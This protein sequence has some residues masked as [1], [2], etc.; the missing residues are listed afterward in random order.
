MRISHL[1]PLWGIVCP[2]PP[3]MRCM[4]SSFASFLN[5]SLTTTPPDPRSDFPRASV[6]DLLSLCDEIS[7]PLPPHSFPHLRL[8]PR[9]TRTGSHQTI[10]PHPTPTHLPARWGATH[11][12]PR[13]MTDHYSTGRPPLAHSML[14]GPQKPTF[15]VSLCCYC[16]Q[17]HG[18]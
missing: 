5:H 12:Q 4:Q 10:S 3:P 13:G 11:T 18:G 15:L 9:P 2:D 8:R 1:A 14:L 6:T 7:I 16:D 17:H